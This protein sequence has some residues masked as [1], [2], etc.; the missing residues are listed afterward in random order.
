MGAAAIDADGLVP[1]RS[2]PTASASQKGEI[3]HHAGRDEGARHGIDARSAL[4]ET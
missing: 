3:E 4:R 1:A 2:A